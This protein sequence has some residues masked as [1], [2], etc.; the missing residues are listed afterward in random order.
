MLI[1][2]YQAKDIFKKYGV[3]VSPGK[4]AFT[5]DEAMEAAREI[6]GERWAV[7][8]QVHAG[9][10]GKGGGIKLAKSIDEV[11][12]F[13]SLMLGM[14]LVTHQTG[15]EG[16]IVRRLLIETAAEIQKE[17]YVGMVVDRKLA[18]PVVMVSAEGGVDIEEVAARSPERIFK[19][20]IDPA[21][22]LQAY[23]ARKLAFAL[24]L[25]K[26]LIRSFCEVLSRLYR[27]FVEKDCSLVEI[28][29]LIVNGEGELQ[30][31]DAKVNFDDNAL[32]R[33]PDV[34]ELRDIEEEDP[35]EA[36]A[37]ESGLSYVRLD[38]SIGCMVNGAGLA[39][40]T[41]DIIQ[42]YGAMP[43]NFLDVGGGASTEA[44]TEAFKLILADE[45]VRAVLVNIFGGI[46]KCDVIANGI[47]GALKEVELN[48]PLV[49]RLEG[50]N[51]ELGR[52]ILE[53]SGLPLITAD[54]MADAAQKVVGA[55]R[56]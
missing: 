1:H 33:H 23:Q 5:A 46:M 41:L 34:V 17:Y 14:R 19:E 55:S 30:A 15:P 56:S 47:L 54:G 40:S 53:E 39:M 26:R 31:L 52:K 16:K 3:P 24:G 4:A 44:V 25:D 28:N 18:R 38:G 9:G 21:V 36:R 22:G 35:T 6:G 45:R 32:S 8:A 7:K 10:R 42:H 20:A 37:K 43:A 49:V 27:L 29:P 50:T 11:R 2:E 13:A 48:V 12:E 51:V